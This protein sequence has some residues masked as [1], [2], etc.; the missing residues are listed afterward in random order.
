MSAQSSQVSQPICSPPSTTCTSCS[1][2]SFS[3]PASHGRVL[4]TGVPNHP[5]QDFASRLPASHG[6]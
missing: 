3:T 1:L 4:T 5:G 2:G 6:R